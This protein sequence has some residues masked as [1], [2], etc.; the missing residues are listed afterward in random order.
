MVCNNLCLE[1]LSV[2]PH[3]LP[4]ST[5]QGQWNLQYLG[6]CD[7]L[8]FLSPNPFEVSLRT[9]LSII[10]SYS[11]IHLSLCEPMWKVYRLSVRH[12]VSIGTSKC[13]KFCLR[14]QGFVN[15]VSFPQA[16]SRQWVQQSIYS[17][18]IKCMHGNNQKYRKW[19]ITTKL[20]MRLRYCAK[21]ET[22]PIFL[23]ENCLFCHLCKFYS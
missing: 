10:L 3:S 2:P 12:S 14:V 15:L 1:L 7:V 19:L 18:Q 11:S 8:L 9:N 23:A 6:D 17:Q 21:E 4:S 13:I 22:L 16:V 20:G 5:V